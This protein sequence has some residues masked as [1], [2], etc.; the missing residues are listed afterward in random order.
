MTIPTPVIHVDG[1]TRRYRDLR[2]LDDVSFSVQRNTITGLLGR[3]GAGKSTL[4]RVLTGQE[5]P[6]AG[7]ARVLGAN[8]VENSGVLQRICFISESQRYP[9]SFQARHVLTSAP[10]FYANW[11]TDLADRLVND[12]RLPLKREIRK[13]SRGQQSALGVIVGLASQAPITFFDEPYLGLDA[14]ARQ[15]FYDTLLADFAQ[16][17]RTIVLSTHLI[18]EVSDLL[19]HVLVLEQGR[20]MLDQDAESLRGSASAIAGRA[21]EVDRFAEGRRVL[22]RDTLGGLATA[23][24]AGALTAADHRAAAA[25]GLEIAPVSVQQLI[26]DLSRNAAQNPPEVSFAEERGA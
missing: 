2:A 16:R 19:E 6:T 24:I 25:A 14:V 10:W 3:N 23:T 5:F 18:D 8:P 4:M 9:D 20:L 12:F 13:L 1:V 15:L 22:H 11:D 21:A 7:T 26:V 17:P